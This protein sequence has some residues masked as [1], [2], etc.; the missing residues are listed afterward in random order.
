M[1][2][3][4]GS[5]WPCSPGS[6]GKSSVRSTWGTFPP[7]GDTANHLSRRL[8]AEQG[9]LRVEVSSQQQDQEVPVEQEEGLYHRC[10]AGHHP[11]AS[12][13]LD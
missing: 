4:G 12:H 2:S 8:P 10:K 11:G 6:S 1:G 5:S 13:S 3:T 7:S 9:S